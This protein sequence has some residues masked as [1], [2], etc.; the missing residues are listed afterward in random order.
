ESSR[1][2]N[3]ETGRLEDNETNAQPI[4]SASDHFI[5]P[6]PNR[7][8]PL[9]V[10]RSTELA[11][12]ATLL[13]QPTP[14]LITLVGPPGV[15]KTRLAQASVA[16]DTPHRFVEL[17]AIT[18]PTLV[19]TTILQTLGLSSGERSAIEALIEALRDKTLILVL[20]NFE[21]VLAAGTLVL[22]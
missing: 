10:G 21:Q 7:T 3:Q 20:D 6:S 22:R 17:G 5:A 13:A 15:G 18:D 1:Q 14:R 16:S 4:V 11:N 12:L 19:A 2:G 9:L 8:V